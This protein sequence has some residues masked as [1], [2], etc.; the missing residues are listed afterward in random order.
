M[1]T[2]P[3]I[4]GWG[5]FSHPKIHLPQVRYVIRKGYPQKS[6]LGTMPPEKLTWGPQC[7]HG[8]V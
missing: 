6:P 4:L 8:K 2:G 3:R 5:P 1:V 7:W